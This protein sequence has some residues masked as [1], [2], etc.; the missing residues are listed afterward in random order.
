M[1]SVDR[2]LFPFKDI[3]ADRINA[4]VVRFTSHLDADPI[5]FWLTVFIS[6]SASAAHATLDAWRILA[7]KDSLVHRHVP[8]GIDPDA[9]DREDYLAVRDYIGSL[10]PLL[11]H[12]RGDSG[13]LR[14][15]LLD[16]SVLFDI[17]RV[18]P[19]PFD[20]FVRRVDVSRAIG[21][22][23]DYIGGR[24][25]IVESDAHGRPLLQAERNLYLPQPN[26]LALSG[27]RCIDVTKLECA[28]YGDDRHALYWQTVRSENG[29]ARYDDGM[30]SFERTADGETRSRVFGRQEFVLPPLWEFVNLP[31]Y[32]A[33]K[34]FLVTSAYQVFFTRT[35]ANFEAVAEGRDVRIG[36][37]ADPLR[38]E[39][40]GTAPP[41]LAAISELAA[42]ALA[43]L[44][45]ARDA[46]KAML[47]GAHGVVPGGEVDADGFVHFTAPTAAAANAEPRGGIMEFSRDL[48]AML[49]RDLVSQG[50]P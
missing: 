43:L 25:V 38:G 42:S 28:A 41:S 35:F 18:I 6:Y 2:E 8:L 17:S 14:W 19:V 7:A 20:E 48:F 44:P 31:V 26:Y 33:L 40:G 11:G 16:G 30:V 23:N 5:A 32:A 36:K 47:L 24:I 46:T 21:F 39:D 13:G 4:A 27:G 49:Q 29:S 34:S 37:P 9:Y 1:Q 3:L 15:T 12:A 10:E 22:M 45:Q 50:R